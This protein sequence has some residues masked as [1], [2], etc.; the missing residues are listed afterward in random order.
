MPDDLS[1]VNDGGYGGIGDGFGG[2]SVGID[3][4]GMGGA[5]AGTLDTSAISAGLQIGAAIGFSAGNVTGLASVAAVSA[6]GLAAA[7]QTIGA[8]ASTISQDP[9][10]AGAQLGGFGSFG[11]TM[12]TMAVASGEYGAGGGG[13]DAFGNPVYVP[14]I[15][16][17]SFAGNA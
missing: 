8:I 17:A 16:G 3:A 1:G 7:N 4:L 5:M 13:V 6:G 12:D 10:T 9:N 2:S 11:A 15:D 14:G